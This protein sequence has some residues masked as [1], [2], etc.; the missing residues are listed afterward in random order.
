MAVIKA[1]REK[2]DFLV[3]GLQDHRPVERP[4]VPRCLQEDHSRAG[5]IAA[6]RKAHRKSE[7]PELDKI[8]NA[9]RAAG[10]GGLRNRTW[11]GL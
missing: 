10:M 6:M 4:M 2:E 9:R 3:G 7:C 5:A 11:K 8:V 1:E